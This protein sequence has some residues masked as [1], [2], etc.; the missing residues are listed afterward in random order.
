MCINILS[1]KELVTLK[2]TNLRAYMKMVLSN[3]CSLT[4]KCLSSSTVSGGNTGPETIDGIFHQLKSQLSGVDLFDALRK[5]FLYGY[6]I[7]SL[8]KKLDVLYASNKVVDFIV[9]FGLLFDH[10][11]VDFQRKQDAHSKWCVQHMKV[12]KHGT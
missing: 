10:I 9:S 5:D 2:K 1:K 8:L 7:K 3:K 12:R 11:L 4:D 6:G